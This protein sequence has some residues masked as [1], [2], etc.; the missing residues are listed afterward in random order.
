MS[1]RFNV[2]G[3]PVECDTLEELCA[4]AKLPGFL[5]GKKPIA[6]P[7]EVKRSMEAR[8]K[9]GAGP[10]R[11]WIEAEEYAKKHGIS[12]N[13]ARSVIAKKKRELVEKALQKV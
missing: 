12:R 1:Y 7:R 9:Q 4:A 13:E 3:L 11:S 10:K 2:N 5:N 8:E 6:E